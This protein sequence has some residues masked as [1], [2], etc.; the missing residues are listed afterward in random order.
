[1]KKRLKIN[2]NTFTATKSDQLIIDNGLDSYDE[3]LKR[4]IDEHM[5][6]LKIPYKKAVDSSLRRKIIEE[7]FSSFYFEK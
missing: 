3:K 5:S 2:L 4:L 7:G 6:V 1:M